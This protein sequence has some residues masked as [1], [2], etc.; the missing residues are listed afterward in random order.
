MATQHLLETAKDQPAV[1][2]ERTLRSGQ[3]VH[4]EGNLVILGD[5]NPGAE[6]TATGDVVVMGVLRG[7]V[8]T[9]ASGDESA[10]VIAFR[11]QP[12]QLRIAGYIARSPDGETSR[13]NQPEIASVRDGIVTI[14]DFPIGGE[15]SGKN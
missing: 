3:I 7:T 10:T 13:P 9:G 2:I 1:L 12:T 11:L 15:R 8:H 5:V 4:Y 14:E 6:V